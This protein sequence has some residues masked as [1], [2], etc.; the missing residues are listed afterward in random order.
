MAAA[1]FA[2][3]SESTVLITGE[4]GTGKGHLASYIH[5]HSQRSS[6]SFFAI[7]CATVPPTLAESE[8]FGH[9]AGAFTSA[10]RR[11]RG[12]LELAE[13][14]TLLLDEIGDLSLRV[15]AELLTF[16]DSKSL[17]RVG[18]EQ[19]ITV[20]TRLIVATHRNLWQEVIERRFRA[21]LY[22]RLNVLAIHMPPLRERLEDLPVL[23]DL[24][25]KQISAELQLPSLPRIDSETMERMR[26]YNWPGNVRELR[27]VLER[28]AIL[29]SGAKLDSG[30]LDLED[31]SGGQE[32]L[33]F[34]VRGGLPFDQAVRDFKV[35][36]VNHALQRTR[37][38]KTAA[39]RLL[40]ISRHSIINYLK[41][42][43]PV[44][45]H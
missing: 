39:A 5:E 18:G 21:D 33:V 15:Q 38:N 41:H 22:Y 9:E 2:A 20:D 14:G 17:T 35:H 26:R 27:N 44:A 40:G 25:L 19:S 30:L 10:T 4:S 11:K 7:N 29:S 16:L 28:A 31:G 43:R 37:G 3:Q 32:H 13:G 45:S 34:R 42:Q 1:R 8:L 6:G 36:L 12:L 24:V 23:T